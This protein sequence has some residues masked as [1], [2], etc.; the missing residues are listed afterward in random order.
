MVLHFMWIYTYNFFRNA[1]VV[2]NKYMQILIQDLNS[3]S[4]FFLSWTPLTMFVEGHQWY[5]SYQYPYFVNNDDEELE[6]DSYLVPD[7]DLEDGGLSNIEDEKLVLDMNPDTQMPNPH[8]VISH[9]KI[10]LCEHTDCSS[11]VA[12]TTEEL[13]GT[14]CDFGVV[15]GAKHRAF[16]HLGERVRLCNS[17]HAVFCNN[18]NTD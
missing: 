10:A 18:C 1:I 17:C 11:F 5:W 12:V 8:A 4:D 14:D 7:S 13:T 9:E 15:D 6:F 16:T 2:F 3:N